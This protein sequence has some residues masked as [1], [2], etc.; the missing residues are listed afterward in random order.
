METDLSSSDDE[1]E[2]DKEQNDPEIAVGNKR[3]HQEAFDKI[4]MFKKPEDKK[5]TVTSTIA[6]MKR[7]KY[8]E[9]KPKE[10]P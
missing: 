3:K 4:I 9:D 7:V 6:L 5:P 8:D 10:V 1:S 2:S